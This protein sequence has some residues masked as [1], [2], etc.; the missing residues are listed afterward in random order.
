MA[1]TE[2]VAINSTV[3]VAWSTVAVD[4]VVY[5]LRNVFCCHPFHGLRVLIDL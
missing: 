3:C 2:R 1:V 4:G 5:D